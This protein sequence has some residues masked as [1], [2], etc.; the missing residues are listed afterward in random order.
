MHP[1]PR[2]KQLATV[3]ATLERQRPEF[4]EKCA[5]FKGFN[6]MGVF[7]DWG[8]IHQKDPALFDPSETPE[9]K[10]EGP[11]REAFVADLKAGRRFYGGAAYEASRSEEEKAA[12]RYALH[13]TMDL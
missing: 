6:E 1:D 3:A 4:K 10:P 12:F 5:S 11:E 8:S 13:E 2:G 9:A 7:W